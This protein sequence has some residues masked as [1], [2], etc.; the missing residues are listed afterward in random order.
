[1]WMGG[2]GGG[3]EGSLEFYIYRSFTENL[4]GKHK[5]MFLLEG[6]SLPFDSKTTTIVKRFVSTAVGTIYEIRHD[7]F[8]DLEAQWLKVKQFSYCFL[9]LFLVNYF[10][11]L[12][13]ISHS[14]KHVMCK[15]KIMMMPVSLSAS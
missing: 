14:K 6:L 7:K 1:M 8:H 4:D 2:G 9:F 10:I 11:V 12:A 3:G 5:T 15:N 13:F